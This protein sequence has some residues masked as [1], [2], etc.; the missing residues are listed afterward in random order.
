VKSRGGE[1]T[2]K[3]L[4]VHKSKGLEFPVVFMPRLNKRFNLS[5]L[6][7]DMLICKDTGI[8]LKYINEKTLL[9]K[10]TYIKTLAKQKNLQSA[11]SEELRILYVG[12]TRAK[13]HL[14]LSGSVG[15]LQNGLK[16]W[17]KPQT[18]FSLLK[19]RSCLDWLMPWLLQMEGGKEP[20]QRN[21]P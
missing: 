16:K 18:L 9:R 13:Q 12:F 6:S 4:S 7:E 20:V 11:L 21:R 1:N 15:S 10:D 17:L 3:I 2:V 14:I 19:T 5:E 8:A